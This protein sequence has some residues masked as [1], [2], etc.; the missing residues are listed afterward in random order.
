MTVDIR[1]PPL[2]V[3]ARHMQDWD[4]IGVSRTEILRSPWPDPE[5]HCFSVRLRSRSVY[6]VMTE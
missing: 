2:L 4:P 3:Y 5:C 6:E 1:L